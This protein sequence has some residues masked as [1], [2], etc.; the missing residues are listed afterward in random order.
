VDTTGTLSESPSI[1]LTSLDTLASSLSVSTITSDIFAGYQQRLH[2]DWS[3]L[4]ATTHI[5]YQIFT[6]KINKFCA[7]HWV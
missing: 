4:Y 2:L 6:E 7:Q 5:D 1:E 3:T